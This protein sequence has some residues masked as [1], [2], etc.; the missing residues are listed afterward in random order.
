LR[1]KN[2]VHGLKAKI[3]ALGVNYRILLQEQNAEVLSVKNNGR[4]TVSFVLIAV[5]AAALT[6]TSVVADSAVSRLI[7]QRQRSHPINS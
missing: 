2:S 1:S 4:R 6:T 5:F 7:Q 3:D